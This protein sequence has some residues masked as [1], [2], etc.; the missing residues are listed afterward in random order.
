MNNRNYGFIVLLVS[1]LTSTSIL[2][3]ELNKID[4][5]G[6]QLAWV[7]VP[8]TSTSDEV[9]DSP[10]LK[11]KPKSA[12]SP[13]I[14]PTQ[15]PAPKQVLTPADKPQLQVPA[16]NKSIPEVKPAPVPLS[17]PVQIPVTRPAQIVIVKPEQ[18]HAIRAKTQPF[19]WVI[20]LGFDFG[21]EELGKLY[22]TDGSSASVKTNNG[23]AINVGGI[24]PNGKNSAFSTQMTLG[25]KYGGPRA[26]DGNVTWSAI[27]LELIEHYRF[28]SLRMGLGLS[29][30]IRPQLNVTLPASAYTDKYNNAIGLIAQIGWAP[31]REHYSIDLRYTSI[32]FEL[33]DVQGA[34]MVDGSSAGIYT[35]YRF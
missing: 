18:Q 35:S 21:G 2:G 34:P 10:K 23:F 13:A 15:V 6:L 25:Y 32:K 29:Y 8:S 14:K 11:P 28:S 4:Y 1:S 5:N 24:L 22:F 30:Q 9:T 3:L 7:R 31:A 27:P 16:E 12:Q 33:S 26:A 19:E 20:G 17:K